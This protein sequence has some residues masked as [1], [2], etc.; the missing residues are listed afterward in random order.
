MGGMRPQ[1]LKEVELSLWQ[2]IITLAGSPDGNTLRSLKTAFEQ[3]DSLLARG[4]D[5]D[6][7][8]WFD[9]GTKFWVNFLLSISHPKT[10]HIDHD[11]MAVDAC[12]DLADAE[13]T[14]E[15]V[16]S[17]GSGGQAPPPQPVKPLKRRRSPGGSV[18]N[19]IDLTSERQIYLNG[20]ICELIDLSQDKACFHEYACCDHL[21]E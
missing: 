17:G 21:T 9:G 18:T 4:V 5:L 1:Q 2:V 14:L 10:A 19:P 12:N 3:I 6:D 7:I 16:P 13:P 20:K 15:V 8:D 11:K